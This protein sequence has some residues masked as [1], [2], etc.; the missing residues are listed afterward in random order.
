VP[1]Q[2]NHAVNADGMAIHTDTRPPALLYWGMQPALILFVF[3]AAADYLP[4]LGTYIALLISFI[5]L[6][7]AE[8]RW[9]ARRQWIQNWQEWGQVLAM[10]AIN[11]GAMFLVELL[12]AV[13]PVA[14]FAELHRVTDLVWPSEW[15][16]LIQTLMAFAI[17]QFIA[18]W[19]HRW[20][21]EIAILWRVFGHGTHHTY[22]KLSA[23]NWNT[24]HPFESVLLVMP[25]AML[26]VL[27]GLGE[28][29][30]IAGA[31]VMVTTACAHTNMRLNERIIGLVFT[32]N[33]QHMQHHS[34]VFAESNTNYGCAMTLWDR[35]FGT[36]SAGD[37][38]ALGDP[39]E[40]ERTLWKRLTLPLKTNLGG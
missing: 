29:A 31:M 3:A 1:H 37:T 27:F 11:G 35:V 2:N 14:P 8:R 16:L 28:V 32:T 33:S 5:A 23:L 20:Q 17:M 40:G 36:F 38:Q 15:P 7:L 4:G 6:T 18:Y 24:T 39:M 21:H 30:I 25:I 34:A 19:S 12:M 22:T 9:P 26:G 10:F 13:V